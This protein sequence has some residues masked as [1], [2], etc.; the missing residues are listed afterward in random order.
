[1]SGS[2]PSFADT[3]EQLRIARGWSPAEVAR[4]LGVYATEVSR[5]RHGGGI[6]IK[7]VRKVADLFGVDSKWLERLAG[8]DDS[9]SDPALDTL[10]D[11]HRIWQARYQHL[12]DVKVPPK[13]WDA[14][15]TA[16]EALADV[17]SG[18]LNTD[19]APSLSKPGSENGTRPADPE[20]HHLSSSFPSAGRAYRSRTPSPVFATA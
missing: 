12:L 10:K 19:S 2:E 15:L 20:D 5:W 14:Y 9:H 6:S 8:Y 4:R 16:C 18:A 1:M 3:F 13:L 7:N 17:F 11:E